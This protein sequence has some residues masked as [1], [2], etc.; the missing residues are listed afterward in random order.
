MSCKE[1]VQNTVIIAGFLEPGNKER[2]ELIQASFAVSATCPSSHPKNILN[3]SNNDPIPDY[4]K[5]PEPVNT[6]PEHLR[7]QPTI[8]EKLKKHGVI[9]SS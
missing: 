2:G 9:A 3:C 7:K 5:R 1:I 6:V 4:L 8:L